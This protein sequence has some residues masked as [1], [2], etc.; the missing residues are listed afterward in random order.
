MYII[1]LLVWL[2]TSVVEATTHYVGAEASG[3]GTGTSSANLCGG[4]ADGDC[5]QLAGDTIYLCGAF[6]AALSVPTS[7]TAEAPITYHWDCSGNP[8]TLTFDAASPFAFSISGKHD[9]VINDLRIHGAAGQSGPTNQQSLVVVTGGAYGV[10]IND[11]SV[12]GNSYLSGVVISDAYNVTL[13][14]PTVHTN[15]KH[16]IHVYR[17]THDI[18]VDGFV[19]YDNVQSG[20]IFIGA[21]P[22][23]N[24]DN[25]AKNG[26]AY[27]NGDGLY[28]VLSHDN[29]FLNNHIYA[30][31][32]VLGNG[33][34]YGIGV[35]QSS[36]M[37]IIGNVIHDNL[38]DGVEVWGDGQYP[39]NQ[40]EVAYNTIYNHTE[41]PL[42]DSFS[43]GIEARTGYS[44]GCKIYQNLLYN[45]SR[46]FRLG[47]DLS[48]TSILFNNQVKGGLHS[49][50]APDSNES[51]T[52]SLTGWRIVG[53]TFDTP[54]TSWFETEVA[55]G[56]R[57]T[58]LGNQW[59][60]GTGATYNGTAYT[61]E[62]ITTLD[63]TGVITGNSV[64]T[65]G[66][67]GAAAT[68][69]YPLPATYVFGRSP[70]L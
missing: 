47:N 26:T 21:T 35:Q 43:N 22:S 41:T 63:A 6:T 10:T 69:M 20:L 39:S 55:T 30:N 44:Q 65:G 24:Y 50:K 45:N 58:F 14:R 64:D 59:L 46:N 37:K 3:T 4:L 52:N 5:T 67:Y 48:N 60:G 18:I 15:G 28:S 42:N 66:A 13:N 68:R 7:G 29:M 61:A 36:G 34:G 31:T 51:G 57:N 17:D 25:I 32:N 16:G 11:M 53:N 2:M 62:T 40:C 8:A 27:G 38:S 49:V 70:R 12:W 1:V 33:E 54:T 19:V 56:N 23:D 9:L